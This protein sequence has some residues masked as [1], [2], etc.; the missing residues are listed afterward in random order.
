M[1][2]VSLSL[3]PGDFSHSDSLQ[4]PKAQNPR[5]FPDVDVKLLVGIL[6]QV[7]KLEFELDHLLFRIKLVL[8]GPTPRC[9][10]LLGRS[11]HGNAEVANICALQD[12]GV[13]NNIVKLLLVTQLTELNPATELLNDVR[14]RPVANIEVLCEIVPELRG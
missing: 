11:D 6:H 9:V 12:V 5:V 14:V 4:V 3:D 13:E 8:L 2:L 10:L 1:R 7:K